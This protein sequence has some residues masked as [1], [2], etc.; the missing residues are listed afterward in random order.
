MS[1]LAKRVHIY[2]QGP[3]AGFQIESAALTTDCKVSI[4]N[5]PLKASGQNMQL[6][7]G[8]FSLCNNHRTHWGT[9]LPAL[10]N[11]PTSTIQT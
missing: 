1:H 5:A 6:T 7:S 11:Q 10:Y 9:T 8:V 4:I 3:R 2:E